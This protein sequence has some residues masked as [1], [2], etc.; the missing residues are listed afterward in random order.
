MMTLKCYTAFKQGSSASRCGALALSG[1]MMET[2][3]VLGARRYEFKDE[4]GQTVRG[5]SF[6]YLTGDTGDGVEQKG[7]T[8]MKISAAPEVFG[9]LQAVPGVYDMD[10]KQRPGKGGRPTLQLVAVKFRQSMEA[11]F[12]GLQQRP[13]APQGATQ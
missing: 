2:C 7:A 5:V 9:Q 13:A 4:S 8:V 1:G 3:I 10:F 12:N 11:M 6:E